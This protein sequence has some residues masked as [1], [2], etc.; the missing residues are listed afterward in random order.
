MKKSVPWDHRLSSLGK[1]R[2]A[3]RG[4]SGRIFLSHPH[5]HDR[6]L[7]SLLL[8]PVVGFSVKSGKP[9]LH[10]LNQSSMEE[11]GCSMVEL[12]LRLK[13]RMIE[14][15]WRHCVVSLSR[16]LCPLLSTDPTQGDRNSSQHD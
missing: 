7:Y 2:D 9:L 8:I 14:P 5:T 13:G 4:S 6:F 15:Q 3:K 12:D 1:P 11:R 16:T 10:K